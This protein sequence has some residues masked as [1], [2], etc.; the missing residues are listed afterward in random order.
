MVAGALRTLAKHIVG[1]YKHSPD[2]SKLDTLLRV[3][4]KL[5]HV[6]GR[7]VSRS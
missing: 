5:G 1:L 7:S 2:K 3:S 6:A 4:C